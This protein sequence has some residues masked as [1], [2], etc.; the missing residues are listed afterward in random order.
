MLGLEKIIA[1]AKLRGIAGPAVV[2]VIRVEWIGSDALNVVYRGTDGPAEVLVFRE[3]E[4]R[5]ELVQ[6]SRKFSFDHRA[7]SPG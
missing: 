7:R 6:A 2:D 5:L 4:P 1:G 3:A